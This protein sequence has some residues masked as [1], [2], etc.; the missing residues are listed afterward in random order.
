MLFRSRRE[1]L[2]GLSHDLRTPL[3]R[4]RLR[5]ETELPEALAAKVEGDVLALQRVV[6][7]FVIYMEGEEAAQAPGRPER[8]SE[9]V[10]RGC[11]PY[12]ELQGLR[13]T[14]RPADWSAVLAPD[15]A[16]QRLLGNLVDNAYAHGR[17][18]VTVSLSQHAGRW[19]L[20]V[21]DEGRGIHAGELAAAQQPFVKLPGGRGREAGH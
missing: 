17:G 13:W 3:A 19:W 11:A 8:L 6:T 10:A 15:L 4:L 5:A 14:V 2:A 7:Q 1:T 21:G 9:L 16:V 12:A 20:W 18:Q